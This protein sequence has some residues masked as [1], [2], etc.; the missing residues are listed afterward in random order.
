MS[1][2]N[3]R[4]QNIGAC[5]TWRRQKLAETLKNCLTVRLGRICSSRLLSG[6]MMV[7][8]SVHADVK[9]GPA[10]LCT[11]FMGRLSP[12]LY[13][14]V[15]LAR[16][17]EKGQNL[18]GY[19][20]IGVRL[21]FTH[22]CQTIAVSISAHRLKKRKKHKYSILLS[23]ISFHN[24]ILQI[25]GCPWD[26][27]LWPQTVEVEGDKSAKYLA[28]DVRHGRQWCHWNRHCGAPRNLFRCFKLAQLTGGG[29]GRSKPATNLMQAH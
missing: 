18:G 7:L 28:F 14:L 10:S 4:W 23:N 5:N 9:W 2:K 21:K 26:Q 1:T 16:H 19:Q 20:N 22:F 24:H 25:R 29:V 6:L 8:L 15:V 3:R 11:A 12:A 13:R 17:A 27:T